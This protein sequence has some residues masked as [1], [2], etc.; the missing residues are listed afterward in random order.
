MGSQPRE[1][2]CVRSF[3]KYG[4]RTRLR[5]LLVAVPLGAGAAI[6]FAAVSLAAGPTVEATNSSTA[7]NNSTPSITTAE[8]V[9]FKNS[10]ASLP[11]GLHWNSPPATPSCPS[12]PVDSS[13]TSWT[14]ECTFSQAGSYPF[15]CTV[16]PAMTGTVTVTSSGPG[17]PNQPPPS[18]SPE[19]PA[20]GP[21]L[22]ALR[23][24]KRQRGGSVRGSVDISHAGAGGRLQVDLFATRAKL[25][26][27]G[28]PG[29]MRVGR[30]TRSSLSEGHVSF[31]VSL[32]GVARRAV[33][34]AERLPLQ[35]EVTVTPRQG[36]ALRRTRA[37]ILHA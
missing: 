1:R 30:L 16:H 25:F 10:S 17:A 3:G 6:V 21:A 12:V 28:R 31:K 36:E 19:S 33:Q 18:G 15:V 9:T 11:H 5:L 23:L 37:V 29:K 35:V 24:A 22:K 27:A 7:W 32:K 26:G 2:R 34:R 20:D 4:F 13:G 14:G 8:T